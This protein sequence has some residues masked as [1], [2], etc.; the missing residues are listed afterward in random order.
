MTFNDIILW[1][2][3]I[4]VITGGIDKLI[5][6]RFG[7]GQKFDEGFQAMGD[8]ALA[9]AGIV[10]LA[11]VLAN[12]LQPALV[13]LFGLFHADP[14]MFASIIANDMGG[15]SLAMSLAKDY[16]VGLMSGCITASMLGCTLVFSLPVGLGLIEKEDKGYFCQGLLIGLITV[17]VGSMI[18]G[19][20]A[21]FV[22]SKVL[23]NNVPIII[24]S[25]IL[26][27]G[28]KA[29][30]DAMN[31]GT[32]AF[33]TF[34]GW[35]AVIGI[36]IGAFTHLTGVTI[37]LF[38]SAD[39]V[40][41]AMEIVASIVIVLCGIL[42]VLELLTKLLNKALTLFGKLLGIDSV[43]AGGLVFSLANSVPVYGMIKNMGRRGKVINVAWL[44]PATA[45]L[46]DHL[47]FTAGV[48]PKMITPMIIGKLSAGVCAIIIACVMTRSWKETE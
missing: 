38:E 31:K 13:S 34:I 35:L 1:I 44:V 23:V 21:G 46:G 42:P 27:I 4:G 12:W 32:S 16:E 45:A 15:Y 20:A 33:G 8:L 40:M 25:V 30:P 43:S 10:V 14:S 48:E 6:N 41:A 17:P 47:G 36:I 5:G 37:P 7:L 2:V 29:A 9:V 26:A 11:P 18:G 28:L 39:T 22:P 3:A 19:M 24:L